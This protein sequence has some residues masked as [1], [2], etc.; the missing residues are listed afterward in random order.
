MK[1]FRKK[2]NL[3]P[4]WQQRI[5]GLL[6]EIFPKVQFIITTHSPMIVSTTEENEAI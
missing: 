4:K 2:V 1:R 6:K 5:L 3:H